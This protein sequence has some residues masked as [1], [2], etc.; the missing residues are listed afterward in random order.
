MTG[1]QI[2]ESKKLNPDEEHLEDEDAQLVDISK[3][4]RE[5][6]HDDEEEKE[7]GLVLSDSE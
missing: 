6:V 5:E 1:R 3:Y 4:S 7:Q 2:F